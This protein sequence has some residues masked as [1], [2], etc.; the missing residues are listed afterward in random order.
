LA[1]FV[2]RLISGEV[3]LWRVVGEYSAYSPAKACLIIETPSKLKFRVPKAGAAENK[4]K[5]LT[6]G[7]VAAVVQGAILNGEKYTWFA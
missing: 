1:S 3:D 4:K 5:R 2:I 7:S 6:Q